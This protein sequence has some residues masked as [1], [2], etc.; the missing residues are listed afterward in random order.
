[1]LRNAR[2]SI[3]CSVPRVEF[4]LGSANTELGSF[5]R[6]LYVSLLID[7][8]L[9]IRNHRLQKPNVIMCQTQHFVASVAEPPARFSGFVIVIKADSCF[10]FVS[11][12]IR[13]TTTEFAMRWARSSHFEFLF[14]AHF[15]LKCEIPNS[16]CLWVISSPLR[17][18]MITTQSI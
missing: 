7:M 8:F 12:S 18:I 15:F 4:L 16:L 1:M 6:R 5:F 3:F 11:T 9:Q 14:C 10:F 17:C 2:Q 13:S